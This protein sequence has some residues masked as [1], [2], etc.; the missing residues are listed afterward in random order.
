MLR[1]TWRRC[2][3]LDGSQVPRRKRHRI[4]CPERKDGQCG[5]RVGSSNLTDFPK[6]GCVMNMA[7]VVGPSGTFSIVFRFASSIAIRYLAANERRSIPGI[8]PIRSTMKADPHTTTD[9]P[10]R[11]S[12]SVVKYGTRVRMAAGSIASAIKPMTTMP[13]LPNN[14]KSA[15]IAAS[16]SRCRSSKPFTDRPLAVMLLTSNDIV[17][18][19]LAETRPRNVTSMRLLSPEIVSGDSAHPPAMEAARTSW[20]I[21]RSC[22]Q[23]SRPM[24]IHVARSQS[25][26]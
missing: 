11:G 21:R 12:I 4:Y 9:W 26:P 22:N 23:S 1:R 14:K 6:S 8:N 17:G 18:R 2:L 7:R 16:S 3:G 10:S 19:T 13:T 15:S 20:S 5:S 24:T 25:V